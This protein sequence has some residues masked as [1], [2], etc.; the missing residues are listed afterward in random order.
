MFRYMYVVRCGGNG[1]EG[2]IQ[3][4]PEGILNIIYGTE[5]LMKSFSITDIGLKEQSI[6]TV[7]IVMKKQ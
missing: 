5:G 6:R 7:Y 1:L 2:S 3:R 4:I